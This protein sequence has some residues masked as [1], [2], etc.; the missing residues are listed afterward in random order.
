MF[1]EEKIREK[2]IYDLNQNVER[3]SAFRK[4]RLQE[5]YQI[6]PVIKQKELNFLL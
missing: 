4:I 3:Q 2:N 6:V 5:N 1:L